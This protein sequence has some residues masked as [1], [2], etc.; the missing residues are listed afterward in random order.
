[1][2]R[3]YRVPQAQQI[4]CGYWG[5]ESERTAYYCQFHKLL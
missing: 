1:M 3:S 5:Y 4:T 2:E